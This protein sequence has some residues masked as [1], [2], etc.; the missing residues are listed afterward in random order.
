VARSKKKRSASPAQT[1][2]PTRPKRS[3]GQSGS[4]VDPRTLWTAVTRYPITTGVTVLVAALAAVLAWAI[5][6]LPKLTGYMMFQVSATPNTLMTPVGSDRSD[7]QMYRQRQVAAVKSRVV[8]NEALKKPEVAN[9]PILRERSDPLN[10]LEN[11]VRVDFRQGPEFMRVTLEGDDPD[12]LIAILQAINTAY[13]DDLRNKE[14]SLKRKEKQQVEKTLAAY[15]EELANQQRDIRNFQ[16]SVGASDPSVIAVKQKIA[17]ERLWM[18]QKQLFDVQSQILRLDIDF[19]VAQARETAAPAGASEPLIQ[20]AIKGDPEWQR[21]TAVRKDLTEKIAAYLD[22]VAPGTVPPQLKQHEDALAANQKEIEQAAARVRAD[23]ATAVRQHSTDAS[24]SQVASLAQQLYLLREYEKG[25]IANVDAQMNRVKALDGGQ[26]DMAERR[27]KIA[28]KQQVAQQLARRVEAIRVEL[29]TP[30]RAELL[31][32]PTTVPGVEG[33][34][35]LRYAA[36]AAL[37]VLVLGLG[38]NFIRVVRDPR[39]TGVACVESQLGL[40]VVGTLPRIPAGAIARLADHSN[41]PNWQVALSEAL[42]TTRL[43]MLGRVAAGTPVRTLLVTSAM[44]GEGKSSVA[45]QLALSLAQAGHKTVVID[46]DMRRPQL[47]TRLGL[48][49]GPAAQ[50]V[51]HDSETMELNTRLGLDGTLGLAEVLRDELL[52]EHALIDTGVPGL[53]LLAAGRWDPFASRAIT[54]GRWKSLLA[55]LAATHE[56]VVIDSPPLLPVADGLAMAR[57][58][59][60]VVLSVLRDV[61]Q[62]QYVSEAQKR[63][64]AVGANILGVVLSGAD[65]VLYQYA[66][67]PSAPMEVV[68][69]AIASITSTDARGS[70]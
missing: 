53:S 21:L 32:P 64:A 44:S 19:K 34:R 7:F 45:L 6:P 38:L 52:T 67:S 62:L 61:S 14:G 40:R 63:L 31:E 66:R 30:S 15:T 5:V 10:W 1:D 11:Q 48:L 28:E 55:E 16:D 4:G 58:V 68:P 17:D 65:Q 39:V 59:D 9:L 50:G 8:L 47:H 27:E 56:H 43:V 35:R 37:G 41:P 42:N 12:Q 18:S 13:M 33:Y 20:L 69:L 23:T 54:A 26:F 57:D 70:Q 25:L 29:D 46:G 2:A 51:L 49:S 60:G 36:I 3:R 24:K 22:R